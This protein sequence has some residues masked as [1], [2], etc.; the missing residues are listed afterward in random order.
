MSDSFH[1]DSDTIAP[2]DE[3]ASHG[4]DWTKGSDQEDDLASSSS[5]WGASALRS[6]DASRVTASKPSA[7]STRTVTQNKSS[8]PTYSTKDDVKNA[9]KEGD[10]GSMKHKQPSRRSSG[11]QTSS[12]SHHDDRSKSSTMP[13]NSRGSHSRSHRRSDD[14]DA[15]VGEI[16][17]LVRTFVSDFNEQKATIVNLEI[18][19]KELKELAYRQQEAQDDLKRICQAWDGH[20]DQYSA[21]DGALHSDEGSQFADESNAQGGEGSSDTAYDASRDASHAPADEQVPMRNTETHDQ[22]MSPFE[23]DDHKPAP[24]PHDDER[25]PSR[26]RQRVD[27]PNNDQNGSRV[28]N[29]VA[30]YPSQQGYPPPRKNHH[31][32]TN[33]N[34]N[35]NRSGFRGRGGRSYGY[36][37]QGHHPSAGAGPYPQGNFGFRQ[38]DSRQ[39]PSQ[40]NGPAFQAQHPQNNGPFN[41]PVPP[42]QRRNSSF[43]PNPNSPFIPNPHYNPNEDSLYVASQASPP[44]MNIGGPPPPR[45]VKRS[46]QP[47]MHPQYGGEEYMQQPPPPPIARPQWQQGPSVQQGPFQSRPRRQQY[48]AQPHPSQHPRQLQDRIGN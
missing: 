7:A 30:R 23:E 28:S 42:A 4:G 8:V 37:N 5:D 9:K 16:L 14:R 6:N 43:A 33:N 3:F 27:A 19:I 41:A 25:E 46:F 34:F 35:H 38:P 39:F 22:E 32:N 24:A 47:D 1:D 17:T 45:G 2:V 31:P 21:H 40:N 18:E 13:Y 26:K 48:P 29:W 20:D 15:T 10:T 36:H 11:H 44:A 12:S